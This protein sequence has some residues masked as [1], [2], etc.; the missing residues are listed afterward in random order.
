MDA[1]N[2]VLLNK[3]CSLGPSIAAQFYAEYSIFYR[4]NLVVVF[5]CYCISQLHGCL[6]HSLDEGH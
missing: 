3:R 5:I 4:K 2:P 1:M 6:I